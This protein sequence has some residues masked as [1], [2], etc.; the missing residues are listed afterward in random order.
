MPILS[1]SKL[2]ETT[3]RM[4]Y[5]NEPVNIDLSIEFRKQLFRFLIA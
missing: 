5:T 4:L 3:R 2:D 1:L